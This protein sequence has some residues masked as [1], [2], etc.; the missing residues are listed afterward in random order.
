MLSIKEFIQPTASDVV[1][2]GNCFYSE[3]VQDAICDVFTLASG[4]S[5]VHESNVV[6]VSPTSSGIYGEVYKTWE[7]ADAYIQTKFPSSTNRYVIKI[8]GV[9]YENIVVRPYVTIVGIDNNTIL[10]GSVTSTVNFEANLDT[11]KARIVD[12]IIG[13][14]NFATP[15][16]FIQFVR[17]DIMG[18]TPA[19]GGFQLFN[20]SISGGDC[21]N[22]FFQQ[23]FKSMVVGGVLNKG[24]DCRDTELY[25]GYTI[26][27]GDFDNCYITS[28]GNALWSPA[29]TY[30]FLRCKIDTDISTGDYS[31]VCNNCTFDNVPTIDVSTGGF[32]TFISCAGNVTVTGATQNFEN[33]GSYYDDKTSK[34]DCTDTQSAI[35]FLA[36]GKEFVTD[37][38]SNS[39]LIDIDLNV[40][41]QRIVLTENIT[42]LNI[43]NKN[44]NMVSCVDLIIIQ[45]NDSY[46]INW[47]GIYFDNGSAPNISS[48]GRYIIT[49]KNYKGSE[50]YG[51]V[52]GSVMSEVS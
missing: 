38:S 52:K 3:N 8:S 43:T 29:N 23:L 5:Y 26:K 9:N 49:L 19:G 45:G 48:N 25:D 10:L 47:S 24:I 36:T 33:K 13:N 27:G 6:V 31:A 1:F 41:N 28:R 35:D 2:Y 37:V 46:T 16:E 34:I 21:S 40:P 11:S 51:F 18:G 7:E 42:T 50:T 15:Y 20:G 12:C 14:L 17:C 30:R 39:G 44:L 22:L 32:M 4:V